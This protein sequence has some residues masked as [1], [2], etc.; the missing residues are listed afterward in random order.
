MDYRTIEYTVEPD[1]LLLLTLARPEKLN[2]FTV[3]MCEELI[4][5]YG[6][7]SQD[8]AVRVI[9]VTG[10]GRAFCAGMDLG[11]GGNVFGLKEGL[12]PTLADLRQGLDD[13][14]LVHGVRDTG[15]RVAL[16][17][18]DCLK[19]IVGAVNGVAVGIGSTMLLPMDFRLA[20]NNA[21]FGFVFGRLGITLEA[22]SSWFLP[23]I[24][25]LQQALEWVYRADI[26][27]ADE[28]LAKGL[29]R[30][31]HSPETLLSDACEFARSLVA[32]RSPVSIA[33]MRQMLMRNSFQPDP[34]EAHLTESLSV[35]YTSQA[36]GREGVQAFLEK[37]SP[38]FS[39][40][41]SSMPPFYPWWPAGDDG[42]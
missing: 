13:P 11:V 38:N 15:G 42:A 7:A 14:E 32:N 37:R 16:A 1:G 27:D 23:R 18:F 34:L 24:V 21:R 10:S 9:V 41:A 33:L 36:D 19:P 30:S 40:R 26:F 6:R 29:I 2:A 3:E 17:M 28:A 31:V 8:D 20:A 4:D 12:S 35:Y 39:A 25:G 22:C 5:A